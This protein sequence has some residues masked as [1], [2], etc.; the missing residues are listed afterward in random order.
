[1]STVTTSPLTFDEFERLPIHEQPGKRELLDGELTELPP[2]DLEH[3]DFSEEIFFQL[4]QA[5]A[6]AH[7]RGEAT[8]LGKVHHEAGYKLSG[9]AYVQPDVSVTR[10]GQAHAKYLHDAPAIAIEVISPSNTAEQME[11]KVG[12]YFRYGAREV[13]HVYRNPVHIVVHLPDR[14]SRTVL[15]GSLT[16]AL[17]P[18]FELGLAD[19]AALIEKPH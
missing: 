4:R 12:L 15:E 7:L 3:A 8:E 1:M 13:W 14:T 11:K 9:S 17:L 5:L 16:T 10:A 18:S 19:L 2:A 6:A